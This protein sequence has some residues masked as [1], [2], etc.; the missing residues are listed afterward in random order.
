[1]SLLDKCQGTE[2]LEVCLPGS[3]ALDDI[4]L[5]VTPQDKCPALLVDDAGFSYKNNYGHDVTC[6]DVA[7]KY[8]KWRCRKG[9]G[10][11][12]KCAKTCCR[13]PSISE[14]CKEPDCGEDTPYFQGN[15][16][17][18]KNKSCDWLAHLPHWAKRYACKHMYDHHLRQKAWQAYPETCLCHN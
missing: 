1:V 16:C 12:Q 2:L 5:M 4:H 18:Y 15:L 17:L 10:V 14:L 3:G 11:K 9:P 7:N 6:E 8:T 13:V